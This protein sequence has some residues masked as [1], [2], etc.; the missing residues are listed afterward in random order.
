VGSS[1]IFPAPKPKII[2]ALR[3]FEGAHPELMELNRS[4]DQFY[5]FTRGEN[6]LQKYIQWVFVPAVKDASSE[7]LEGKKNALRIL[8]ER[9]VRSKIKFDAALREIKS[10]AEEKYKSLLTANQAALNSLSSSLTQRIQEW[11]HPAASLSV[12]W[13]D[14]ASRYVTVSEPLARVLG[15]EAEF[16]GDLSRFGHGFQRSYLLALLQELASCPDS[17]QP[18]LI[19]A[20][21]EPELHQHPPQARHLTSVLQALSVSGTQVIVAT[22]SPLFVSG[23]GFEDIRLVRKEQGKNT[24]SVRGTSFQE[25]S[26]FVAE[27]RGE[28]PHAHEGIALKVHQA[29]QPHINEM[30]FTDVLILVEGLE[31]AAYIQT[32]VTLM[33]KW[34]DF[35][36][37]GCHIIPA[38]GK[39]HMI[40]PLAIAKKL[41]IPTFVIFDS[42]R[43]RPDKNGSRRKHEIDNVAILRLC[44]VADPIAFPDATLQLKDLVMWNSE[45]GPVVQEEI[46]GDHWKACED[47]IRTKRGIDVDGLD[48]NYLFVGAVLTEAWNQ[49]LRS[50][51]LEQACTAILS[52]AGSSRAKPAAASGA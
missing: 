11:A 39:S 41:C 23:R 49:K 31:D 33:D 32:Y 2:E 44:A 8:L 27:V 37:L 9:T 22:H 35:R 34:D 7:N 51:A 18:N 52:F 3:D 16:E 1:Q 48:K 30:F 28:R 19:L 6:I 4:S 17:G 36:R 14:E 26:N 47:E 50:S 45:I 12:R 25:I 13:D 20:C 43:H 10:Q 5:G 38:G 15:K 40:Q 24:A 46:G 42:D 29:L 21:E